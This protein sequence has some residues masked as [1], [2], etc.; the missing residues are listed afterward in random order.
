MADPYELTAATL[1]AAIVAGEITAEEAASSCLER[2]SG[3]DETIQAWAFLDPAH[4]LRQAEAADLARRLGKPL[5]PLH[6]IP[7]GVKDIID[8]AD[9]PTENGSRLHSGRRPEADAAVVSLLREAGAVILGKTVTTEF[10]VYSPG[11]TRNP[12]DPER[13]PGGS[14]SG[15]AA[16]VS[17]GMVP[18]AL[19]TQTNGSIIRPASFC[20]VFGYKPSFGLISR[21]GILRQSEHLDHVGFFARDLADLAMVAEPLITYDARDPGMRPQAR[22]R[23]RELLAEA[24]PAPPRIAFVRTPIWELA[25]ADTAAAFDELVASLGERVEEIALPAAYGRAIDVHRTILEAGLAYNLKGERERGDQEMSASL[26]E[27]IDR[28]GEIRAVDYMK[29]LRDR[30]ILIAALEEIFEWFD[31]ILTPAAAGEAPKGLGSTGNPAF[32]TT[33]TLCGTPAITL[34]ILQGANGM[35]LGAQL[36]GQHGDDARLM[37]TARWLVD[38]VGDQPA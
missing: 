38:T 22:P 26:R 2:I 32:C 6:G 7:I 13:T 27:M 11:K 14:S 20:G 1:G 23:L 5:G 12:Y 25:D 21:R 31:A 35:P 8:T 33:W 24:P 30:S 15:S 36:V 10:A 28:G 4:A 29:A 9:M 17:A 37:R 16:A 19:G 3:I 18:I 34:P